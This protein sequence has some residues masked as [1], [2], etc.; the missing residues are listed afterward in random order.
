M[1]RKTG[2]KWVRIWV[3]FG[4]LGVRVVDRKGGGNGG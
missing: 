1:G 2:G 4:E 3:E